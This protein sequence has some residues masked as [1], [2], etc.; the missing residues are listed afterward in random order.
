MIDQKLQMERYIRGKTYTDEDDKNVREILM[1]LE[2]RKAGTA[3]E[4]R[5]SQSALARIARVGV[6]TL[7]QILTGGYP[8]SPTKMLTQ[9]MSA[10]R[11]NQ[12]ESSNIIP[13]VETSVFKVVITAC[14]MARRNRNFSLISAFVGTG[15]TS[16]L[17][18]Y[19]KENS[20]V[21]L[22]EARPMMT[23]Q[24]LVKE[25]AKKVFGVHVKG[26]VDDL[27]D[28]IVDELKNTDSL[29]IFDEAET[30]T[31][32]LLHLLRRFRDLMNIG[33]VI[34]GTEYLN[35]KIKPTGGEFD[36]IR[37]RVGFWPPIAH[38]ITKDDATALLAAGFPDEDLS[39][40]FIE[41]CYKYSQGSARML[42]ENLLVNIQTY[43]KDHPLSVELVDTVATKVL[44]LK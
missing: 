9:V 28:R 44:F 26:S 16:A 25:I 39:E 2:E 23:P 5:I 1:F 40:D 41:R 19:A 34:S 27:I 32:S 31:D 8:G 24:R 43:R 3:T 22:I 30:V 21:F 15:K 12:Q 35:D 33:V 37:S 10:V 13:M 18:H 7:S 36:Q 14:R 42:V 17:K 6:S 20:N 11:A 4:K 29:I 38:G